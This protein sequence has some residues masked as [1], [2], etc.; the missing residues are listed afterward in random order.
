M[1]QTLLGLLECLLRPLV[2]DAEG[3]LIGY[4]RHRL[5]G[6][7]EP[8]PR[9]QG[10]DADQPVAEEQRVARKRDHALA[11]GPFLVAERGIA[12]DFIGRVRVASWAM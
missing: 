4:R 11:A 8:L 12:A 9:E 2:F 6:V 1:L 5:Q 10:H 3:N 7:L